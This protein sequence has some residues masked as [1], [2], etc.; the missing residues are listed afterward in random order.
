M[1]DS[2]CATSSFKACNIF[3]AVNHLTCF[4]NLVEASSQFH[5]EYASL[6]IELQ[7]TISN[8]IRDYMYAGNRIQRFSDPAKGL[9]WIIIPDLKLLA[10]FFHSPMIHS[11][12]F[13]VTF[14]NRSMK[15][16]PI[17][18]RYNNWMDVLHLESVQ[19]LDKI[20]IEV[21][22]KPGSNKNSLGSYISMYNHAF[23]FPELVAIPATKRGNGGGGGG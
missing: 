4:T 10:F 11:Q 23:A 16:H 20:S 18:E 21:N 5:R 13:T 7:D 12:E 14:R 6:A 19:N 9:S 1:P 17:P 8:P 2:T 3:M 15:V 22:Y